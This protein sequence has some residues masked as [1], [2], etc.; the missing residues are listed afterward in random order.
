MRAL[1]SPESPPKL[2]PAA[3]KPF[4]ARPDASIR[5]TVRILAEVITQLSERI[6]LLE[7]RELLHRTA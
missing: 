1:S 6:E 3:T 7:A 2:R 4:G 5:D